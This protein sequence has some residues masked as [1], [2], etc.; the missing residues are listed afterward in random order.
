MK[1]TRRTQ[2]YRKKRP[3]PQ[4]KTLAAM[5][6][7]EPA[8]RPHPLNAKRKLTKNRGR[9]QAAVRRARKNRR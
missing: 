4:G 8:N 7:G 6:R 1:P 9:I 5:L 3:R 2:P